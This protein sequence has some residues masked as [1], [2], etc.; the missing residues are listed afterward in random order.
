M[1]DRD[2]EVLDPQQLYSKEYCI[3]AFLLFSNG[4]FELDLTFWQEEAALEKFTRG[5]ST[6]TAWL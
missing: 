2:N 3:G 5:K 4:E 6:T 1:A